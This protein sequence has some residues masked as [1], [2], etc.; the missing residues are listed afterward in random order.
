VRAGLVHFQYG[1]REIMN[2]FDRAFANADRAAE[3]VM[4]AKWFIGG[5][6]MSAISI[7]PVSVEVSA[8][9]GGLYA[10]ATTVIFVRAEVMRSPSVRENAVVNVGGQDLRIFKIERETGMI[11]CGPA[12]VRVPR[13]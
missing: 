8:M 11:V 3:R 6:E 7:D 12:S 10:D 5:P 2:D 4:G 1:R 9:A 13:G